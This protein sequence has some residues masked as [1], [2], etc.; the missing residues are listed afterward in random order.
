MLWRRLPIQQ[1]KIIE[2]ADALTADKFDPKQTGPFQRWASEGGV[3]WAS[4]DVLT[5][6][7]INHSKLVW[8]G[9][10]LDCT[11]SKGKTPILADCKKVVLKDAGGKAHA[12]TAKGAV[13]LLVLEKDIP[14]EDKAGT[15]CWSLVPY[16][17]G[18]VSDP[19]PVDATQYD[20]GQ[21]W[22]NFCQ[23]CL[24]REL[25]V[26]T[27]AQSRPSP[28]LKS[29]RRRPP[30]KARFPAHGKRPPE[31]SF[32]STTR[33]DG[34]DYRISGK[35]LRSF[36]GSLVRRDNDP[37]STS[38]AG[39]VDAV[40]AIDANKKYAVEYDGDGQRPWLH[41]GAV[42]GLARVE[43]QGKVFG[44]PCRRRRLDTF[45]KS[46]QII[47]LGRCY[48]TYKTVGHS[49]NQT[50]CPGDPR[51]N[52]YL[53]VGRARRAYAPSW[54]FCVPIRNGRGS[55]WTLMGPQYPSPPTGLWQSVCHP[56]TH[57]I[58][59]KRDG[60]FPVEGTVEVRDGQSATIALVWQPIPGS[61][62]IGGP[63]VA[64]I[65][66]PRAPAV[67]AAPHE[68]PA[69]GTGQMPSQSDAAPTAMETARAAVL[70]SLE[71]PDA[72]SAA[73]PKPTKL[74][75]PSSI[76]QADMI[77]LVNEA[78]KLDDAKT[79]AEKVRLGKQLASLVSASQKP[80]ERFVLLR[81]AAELARDAGHLPMMCQMI[82]VIGGDFNMDTLMVQAKM[83]DKYATAAST[84]LAIT[85]GL[86]GAKE[87]VSRAVAE[88]RYDVA[89]RVIESAGGSLRESG[90]GRIRTTRPE[91]GRG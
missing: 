24:G 68:K 11:A 22:P 66:Q 88:D 29:Q 27:A 44:H 30:P 37:A 31:P 40:F 7:G 63:A 74:P 67:P 65:L 85:T 15:A 57:R 91:A 75:L 36:T 55:C 49:R 59:A 78:Y 54:S 42:R 1:A 8:W 18:W 33:A 84:P 73:S 76:V 79:P 9:G 77:R 3:V 12:L 86:E 6:F 41:A 38:L 20:G 26:P 23:F 60:C 48:A 70:A 81:R 19:K 58:S 80:E 62:A 28:P 89:I 10:G 71:K 32:A 21:F 64:Q 45:G 47:L 56:G 82:E 39:K 43:Q 46:A 61:P 25:A 52:D 13:A 72:L 14:F 50:V 4:N 90:A 83:F 2:I 53:G 51:W 69:L 5:L 87:L 35:L 17:K 16:G 34:H